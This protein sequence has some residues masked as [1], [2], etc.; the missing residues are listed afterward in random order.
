MRD[1]EIAQEEE[2]ARKQQIRV[3]R[4]AK[5][6]IDNRNKQQRA[7]EQ[8]KNKAKK[9][10]ETQVKRLKAEEASAAYSVVW[11]RNKFGTADQQAQ[12]SWSQIARLVVAHGSSV[13]AL[14]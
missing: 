12:C 5:K 7:Q 3:D 1:K 14:R 8:A 11:V 6:A 9:D 2:E 4:A 10:K 13:M